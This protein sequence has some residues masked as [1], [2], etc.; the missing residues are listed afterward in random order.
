MPVVDV[1]L[2]S[3]DAGTDWHSLAL[4]SPTG[5]FSV[6]YHQIHPRFILGGGDHGASEETMPWYWTTD[7][8][9]PAAREI[10]DRKDYDIQLQQASEEVKG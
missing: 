5:I 9:K 8:A 2:R 3:W 7:L 4:A 1:M 10:Q 6:F